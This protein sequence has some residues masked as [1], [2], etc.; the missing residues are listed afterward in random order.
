MKIDAVKTTFSLKT[1]K[2]FCPFLHFL[3]DWYKVQYRRY[4]Q[5]CIPWF[6]VWWKSAPFVFHLLYLR[7]WRCIRVFIIRSRVTFE[8]VYAG[9]LLVQAGS[10][11][12]NLKVLH[13]LVTAHCNALL[14]P[15]VVNCCLHLQV[16]WRWR[17]QFTLIT[18][19][20]NRE[21]HRLNKHNN[22]DVILTVHRR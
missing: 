11:R 17:Q 2:E 15:F 10:Q 21:T 22:F 6:W 5:T 12:R 1:V 4:P 14:P 7:L 18:I 13:V 8:I 3:P 20:D 16:G 19:C 9:S